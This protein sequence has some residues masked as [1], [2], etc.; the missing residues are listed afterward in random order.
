MTDFS[1]DSR[2]ILINRPSINFVEPEL[3]TTPDIRPLVEELPQL[4]QVELTKQ[5]IRDLAAA[6]TTLADVVQLRAD[7]KAANFVVDLDA[8]VDSATVEAMK[9]QFPD[10]D[11]LMITYD[12]YRQAK[13]DI[14]DQGRKVGD[15]MIISQRD[16]DRANPDR[17]GGF[18]TTKADN[19]AE[20]ILRELERTGENPFQSTAETDAATGEALTTGEDLVDTDNNA[21]DP[22]ASNKRKKKSKATVS[23]GGLRPELDK[24][25]EIVKPIDMNEFKNILMIILANALWKMIIKPFPGMIKRKLPKVLIKPPKGMEWMLKYTD[26]MKLL[27]AIPKIPKNLKGIIK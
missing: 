9:R 10:S 18:G 16:I 24:R 15:R 19:D 12:Q 17:I 23:T 6:V 3:D 4:D 11:P 8:T 26:F 1:S 20:E 14:Y 21:L 27:P 2:N 5:Q 7:Q 25:A 13:Q 22:F